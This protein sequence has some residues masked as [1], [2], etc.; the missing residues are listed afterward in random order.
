MLKIRQIR[1]QRRNDGKSCC[2]L[3]VVSLPGFHY[4]LQHNCLHCRNIYH[5]DMIKERYDFIALMLVLEW[6]PDAARFLKFEICFA[7]GFLAVKKKKIS[8]C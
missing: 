3:C 8:L 2:F 6:M 1:I 7:L 5:G 4:T